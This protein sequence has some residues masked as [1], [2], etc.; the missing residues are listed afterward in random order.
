[1]RRVTIILLLL[2]FVIGVGY[3]QSPIKRKKS[4]KTEQ[5]Q[6]GSSSSSH[7]N[8]QNNRKKETKP[9]V[10]LSEPDGY[11]NGHGFVDLG[12]PSGTKWATCN[13]GASSPWEF[14]NYYAWGMIDI[15]NNYEDLEEYNDL[16]KFINKDLSLKI[17]N[18]VAS[19][20]LGKQWCIPN[21]MQLQEL[22]DQCK[23]DWCKIKNN[24]GYKITGPNG[25]TIF[26][27][28]GGHKVDKGVYGKNECIRYWSS[29]PIIPGINT[30]SN[31]ADGWSYYLGRNRDYPS[32]DKR[33][34]D[35]S[36][37]RYMGMTIRP[38]VK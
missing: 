36:W 37:C 6:S 38:V 32:N 31:H 13:V 25:K 4:E 30:T 27:P 24:F 21:H 33:I 29:T 34:W 16:N 1:M 19:A 8:T 20:I 7:H 9:I 28:A 10:K 17:E 26:L 35:D 14:G 5:G 22:K 23:W 3:G 11:I 12:L 2:S 18:D 15:Q